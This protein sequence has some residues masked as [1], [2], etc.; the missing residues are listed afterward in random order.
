MSKYA[1]NTLL[2]L[3]FVIFLVVVTTFPF[4][5]EL[6]IS[7][8]FALLITTIF[9]KGVLGLCGFAVLVMLAVFILKKKEGE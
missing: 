6:L 2:R 9:L 8:E 5:L 3:G 4:W 7:T 1:R